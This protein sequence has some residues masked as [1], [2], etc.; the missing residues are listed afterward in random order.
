MIEPDEYLEVFE[1]IYNQANHMSL[2]VE[3]MSI[4]SRLETLIER[5]KFYEIVNL[6]KVLK[7]TL[8][9]LEPFINE[10]TFT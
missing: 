8:Y 2:L 3:D 10:K 1:K 6:N 9:T 5:E 4:L 7:E